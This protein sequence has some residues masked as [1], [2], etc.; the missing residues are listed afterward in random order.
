MVSSFDE[1]ILLIKEYPYDVIT[2]S[3]TWLKNNPHLLNYVTIPGYSNIFRNRDYIRGGGVGVYLRDAIDFKRRTDIENI[4]PELEHIW[5]EIPGRNRHSKSLLGVMYR[6]ERM[7]NF[8]TW[9]DKTENLFSQLNILWDGLTVITGDFNVDLF[10]P[11]CPQVKHYTNMLESLNLHQHVECPTRVTSSSKTMI[12]YII[13]DKPNCITYCNVL[14]CPTISDHDAP[15]ACIN[16]RTNRYQPRFKFIRH[17][18]KFDKDAFIRD[19][20]ELPLNLVYSTDDLDDKLEIFSSLF[21][22]CLDKHAPL[23]RTK[24]TRPPWLNMEDIRKLQ[25][26]RNELRHL[27]HQTNL[28]SV[29]N[30]FREVRNALKTKI[31]K[32]K[33]SFYQKALSS[34]KPKELWQT[35]HRILHSNP[36]SIKADP[37]DLNNHFSFIAQR[38]LGSTPS[39]EHQLGEM[40]NSLPVHEHL[41][42]FNLRHVTHTEVLKELTTIRNDSSTGPD[43]IPAKYLKLVAEY[44]ASPLTHIINSFISC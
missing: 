14:S 29:W 41:N 16:I 27:A 40:I 30:R 10:K 36:Q 13:S 33:R 42:L 22:S 23:R 1:L 25:N 12:D 44:I 2:M 32:I 11:E 15:Y 28:E 5:L 4:E 18:K 34:R 38:L 8:Q 6:S 3:E 17:E 35:I 37:D 21:K 26:E 20:S 31:K 7:Q 39:T 9:I 19:F 43:Q 24:I